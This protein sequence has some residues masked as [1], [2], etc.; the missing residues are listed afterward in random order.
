MNIIFLIIEVYQ[1]FYNNKI[2]RN[3]QYSFNL[4]IYKISIHF[5][6]KILFKIKITYKQKR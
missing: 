2:Q 4:L 6:N 3:F 1:S 5:D